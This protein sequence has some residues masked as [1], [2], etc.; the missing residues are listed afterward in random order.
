MENEKLIRHS[1]NQKG[2]PFEKSGCGWKE[3]I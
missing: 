3:S 2:R 1:E